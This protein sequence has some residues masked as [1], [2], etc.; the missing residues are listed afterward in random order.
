M[1]WLVTD[2]VIRVYVISSAAYIVIYI[3]LKHFI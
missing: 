1:Q 3:G 2:L